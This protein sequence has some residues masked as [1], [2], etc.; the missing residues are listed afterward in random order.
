MHVAS[1]SKPDSLWPAGREGAVHEAITNL[2]TACGK[3]IGSEWFETKRAV[4]CKGCLRK[5]YRVKE[6][7]Q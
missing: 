2:W 5:L 6:A 4:E 1:K 7:G 3:M